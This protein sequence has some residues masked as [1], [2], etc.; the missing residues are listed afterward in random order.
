MRCCVESFI[1]Q[2]CEHIIKAVLNLLSVGDPFTDMVLG[3]HDH[4]SIG[5]RGGVER[6]HV[7]LVGCVSWVA[8]ASAWLIS[9]CVLGSLGNEVH[10]SVWPDSVANLSYGDGVGTA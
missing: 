3:C 6:F 7:I 9:R 10:T 8:L 1:G 2:I 4:G 5:A